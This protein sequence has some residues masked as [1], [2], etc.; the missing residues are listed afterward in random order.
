MK[1]WWILV[2]AVIILVLIARNVKFRQVM[3]DIEHY[4]TIVHK[5]PF[6]NTIYANARLY[7][8]SN[9]LLQ[10]ILFITHDTRPE[11]KYVQ[12]H[13]TNLE[14]YCARHPGHSYK[15]FAKCKSQQQ[16]IHNVYWC[17][18]FLLAEYLEDPKYDYIVWLDS[19][20]LVRMP[21][22]NLL[23]VLNQYN[24][25]IFAG[26]DMNPK[27]TTINAG[28]LIFKNTHI[29]KLV[30]NKILAE[31]MSSSFKIRCQ[32]SAS[33]KLDG[34]WAQ[35]CYEQGVINK[36]I[37]RDFNAHLTMFP[38]SFIYGNTISPEEP[39]FIQHLYGTLPAVRD[40]LFE[41]IEKYEC[42]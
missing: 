23:A 9:Y 4:L 35:L 19:D 15:Y 24:S 20:T 16:H 26:F 6:A 32:N 29:S 36:V 31:Y 28:V 5:K 21:Q 18:M 39:V 10:N 27:H 34:L 3:R 41:Q 33:G 12:L 1:F 2:L 30:L 25:D 7:R 38:S 22:I 17:K 13:N 37:S 8:N 14:K 42:I 11:Q 40:N